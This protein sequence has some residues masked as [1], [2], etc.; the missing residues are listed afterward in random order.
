MPA[1]PL[2]SVERATAFLADVARVAN[3]VSP[4]VAL[5]YLP[6]GHRISPRIVQ[7][8][9]RTD[10]GEVYRNPAWCGENER[11]LGKVA[12]L[13][14]LN[15]ANVDIIE[16]SRD[17]DRSDRNVCS[18]TALAAVPQMDGGKV[19]RRARKSLDFRPG[20]PDIKGFTDRQAQEAQKNVE[21]ICEAKCLTKLARV[22]LGLKQKYTLDELAKPFVVPVLVFEPDMNDPEIKR[23]VTAAHLGAAASLYGPRSNRALIDTTGPVIDVDDPDDDPPAP[24]AAAP[25]E[26]DVVDSDAEH[27]SALAFLPLSAAQIATV[28]DDA[29]GQSS[30][31]KWL[32]R[33]SSMATDVIAKHPDGRGRVARAVG[34]QDLASASKGDLS[35]I[36]LMLRAE[37]DGA[38]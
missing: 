31:R 24:A 25:D 5:D 23:M 13:K 9:A 22:V 1:A 10:A 35:A 8:D 4:V 7:I 36:G 37:L 34:G 2:T 29:I 16:L 32:A 11:A 26:F 3:L 38:A 12:L 19:L 30:R 20:S 6:P 15:A 33:L 27:L 21:S 17:D 28:P 14:L 18:Y